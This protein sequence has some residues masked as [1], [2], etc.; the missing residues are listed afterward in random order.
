MN[1]ENISEEKIKE[2]KEAEAKQ[3]KADDEKVLKIVSSSTDTFE[4]EYQF[5]ELDLKF[6]VRLKIPSAL[7]LAKISADVERMFDGIAS[8][9][10]P[11]TIDSYA[12]LAMM[13]YQHKKYKNEE[14]EI[15]EMFRNPDKVYNLYPLQVIAKDFNEFREGFRY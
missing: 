10:P 12:M 11:T 14:V 5:A 9:M 2:L 1:N 8:L 4:K 15:P 3:N 13:S 7:D 6:N